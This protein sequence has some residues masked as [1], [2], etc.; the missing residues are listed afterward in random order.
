M[1]NYR[2]LTLACSLFSVSTFPSA[3]AGAETLDA[4]ASRTHYHGIAFDRTGKATLLL[5]SHHG[6]FALDK[7]GRVTQVSPVQDFMGFSA[8]PVDPLSFYASGHPAG[9]GNSGF[10][11]SEDG[12]VTWKQLSPALRG[13]VDFHQM[14]V[15]PINPEI[16]FGNYGGMQVSRDGGQTW[17]DAGFSPLKLVSIAASGINANLIYAATQKGLFNSA[18]AGKNWQ[19]LDFDGKVVSAVKIAPNGG[20]LAFVL[21]QGLMKAQ[22]NKPKEW[23]VLSNDFGDAYPLHIAIDPADDNHFALT[24]QNNDVL[25]SHDGGSTWAPFGKT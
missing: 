22:E 8:N 2:A 12:G 25:E 23:T 1:K 21:G 15:S 16:I 18:D 13:P 14:D 5:A 4:L 7:D 3:S 24:T 10:L 11:K 19:L 17:A 20:V 9:G 6:L